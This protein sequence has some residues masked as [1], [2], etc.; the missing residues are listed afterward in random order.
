MAEQKS[1]PSQGDVLLRPVQV[2]VSVLDDSIYQDRQLE[3]MSICVQ[4]EPPPAVPATGHRV[5][6]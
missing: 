5:G 4:T 2:L 3:A 6:L 1:D